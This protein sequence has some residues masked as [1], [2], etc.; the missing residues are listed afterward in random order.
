MNRIWRLSLGPIF[1]NS[2][3][4]L[5]NWT[6]SLTQSDKVVKWFDGFLYQFTYC[7][8]E[9]TALHII[10]KPKLRIIIDFVEFTKSKCG[11]HSQNT[12]NHFLCSIYRW[13]YI[14][15]TISENIH[16]INRPETPKSK[17]NH[18]MQLNLFPVSQFPVTLCTIWIKII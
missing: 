8:P 16:I 1:L 4:T 11:T 15:L 10:I 7:L 17:W 3:S 9:T 6:N 2:F 13:F 18:R 12:R 5:C 14:N